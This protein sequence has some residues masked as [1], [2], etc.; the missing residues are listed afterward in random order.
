MTQT[1]SDTNWFN[2]FNINRVFYR[3]KRRSQ[4]TLYEAYTKYGN[5][6]AKVIRLL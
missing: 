4:T 3:K 1:H 6:K 5:D 2:A